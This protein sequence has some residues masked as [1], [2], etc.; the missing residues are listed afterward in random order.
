[1][2]HEDVS[3]WR[4]AQKVVAE[5][6]GETVRLQRRLEAMSIAL[7]KAQKRLLRLAQREEENEQLRGVL[8]ALYHR[9]GQYW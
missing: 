8:A 4:E 3:V 7:E 2:S 1:V 6:K 5:L 9:I